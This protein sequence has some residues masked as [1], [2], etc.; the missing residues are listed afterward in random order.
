MSPQQKSLNFFVLS[1]AIMALAFWLVTLHQPL[2]D[3]HEFRQ[4]Q[5]A[6]TTLFMRPSIAGL[7][8]YETPVVGAPWAIPFEFPL[9]QA[10][11]A[12]IAAISP[13][14][15]SSSGRLVSLA[16]GL[17]CLAPA[18]GLMRHFEVSRT[19]RMTFLL[20]YFTSSIY[21]YWNRSF[22]IE[23]TA[24][25]LTLTSLYCYSRLRICLRYDTSPSLDERGKGFVFILLGLA[26]SMSLGLLVK[27][28]TAIPAMLLI[29][30][31]WLSMVAPLLRPSAKREAGF[32]LMLLI[33]ASLLLSFLLL[34]VWVS[35]CDTIKALNPIGSY[36]TSSA[37]KGWN[38]GTFQ[39]RLSS[40]LWVGVL[41]QRM[42]TP[43]GAV[44]V[45][46]LILVAL[47]KRS[48]RQKPKQLILASITL[49]LAP[50][51]IF[52]NLHVVHSYYQAGNQ[53]YLLVA[54][55]SAASLMIERRA[56]SKLATWVLLMLIIA[57]NIQDFTGPGGYLQASRRSNSA[58]LEAGQFIDE[59]TAKDSGIVV[60][61][62][63]WNSAFAVHSQRRSLAIPRL[64][65]NAPSRKELLGQ[66]QAWLGGLP[67][68]AVISEQPLSQEELIS[69]NYSC[70]GHE[71]RTFEGW[72]VYHCPSVS[73]TD[74]AGDR[75]H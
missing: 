25:F 53:V 31:D 24:L 62:D 67:L 73:V 27:A 56:I 49:S 66:P 58:K 72:M 30:M 50:L 74:A 12:L 11:T 36:L 26:V 47:A 63:G 19:G 60:F 10:I 64:F 69:L 6:L 38:Y 71:R 16:F 18:W 2:I 55:A 52:T 61:G 5:T 51:L 48:A 20:L 1:A 3:E 70:P 29:G 33:G 44:P 22:M 4:T 59:K 65:K 15:L 40:E 21:L 7:L 39:Q 14:S 23:S 9:Y 13:W 34:T 42:L 37:L 54:M 35:H 32:R 75:N 41:I 8:S 17:A 45:V 57:G 43:L 68:G 28:T 46:I